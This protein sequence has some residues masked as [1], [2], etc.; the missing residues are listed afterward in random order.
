MP[1]GSDHKRAA[2]TSA[3]SRPVALEPVDPAFAKAV[4]QL[5]SRVNFEHLK[6]ASIRRDEYKLDRMAAL[7]KVLGDPQESVRHVHV[8]GT[9]GKGSTCWM[10]AA[11]LEGC[12]YT[13]GLYTSPHLVDVRERIC[14]NRQMVSMRDFARLTDEVMAAAATIEGAMGPCTFFELTTMMALLHFAQQAVDIAV[15]EVGLGGLLDCTNIINPEVCGIA[16]IG[17]DHMQVLGNTVELIAQQKAGIFKRGVPAMVI[18]QDE[19]VLNV[20]R[21]EAEKRG[22]P[23]T[24]VGKDLDFVHRVDHPAGEM[25]RCRVSLTT[26]RHEYEFVG[27]PLVGEYQALNCGL[28]LAMVDR[29]VERGFEIDPDRALAGLQTTRVPGRFEILGSGPRVLLDGAHNGD[30]I[31]ALMKAIGQ[32]LQYDALVV[33]F[34]CAADKDSAT[35]LKHLAGAADK[36]I[37]TKAADNSRAADPE[38]LA[39]EYAQIDEK[40]AMWASTLEEALQ[41]AKR[42]ISGGD[43]LAI[44]G[45]FYLVGEAKKI[46]AARQQGRDAKGVRR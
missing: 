17:M 5:Y 20:M 39:R 9:K 38:A 26:P 4:Q 24:I 11:M 44:T 19:A 30:S 43:V 33:I 18:E 15:I 23:L 13:A 22:T 36:V 1:S 2:A 31:K 8:A 37:F 34:G 6:P 12:G 35:M 27:V 14:I 25:P 28:A 29:L 40:P 46:F 42:S 10:T 21:Q 7:A 16:T 3:A 32:F 45:S 41:L